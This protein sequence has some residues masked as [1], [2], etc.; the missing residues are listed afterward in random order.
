MRRGLQ[1]EAAVGS[2]DAFRDGY[3]AGWRSVRGPD[4]SP[5][6]PACPALGG[7]PMYLVGLSQGIRDARVVMLRHAQRLPSD[8]QR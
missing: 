6:V 2:H 8:P 4:E 3:I 1:G 5:D 7:L